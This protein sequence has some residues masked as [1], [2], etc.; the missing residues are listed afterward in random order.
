MNCPN[1]WLPL[2]PSN[3]FCRDCGTPV[4]AKPIPNREVVKKSSSLPWIIAFTSVFIALAVVTG[5]L[6][7]VSLRDAPD[8]TPTV[9]VADVL[10][11]E[12][13]EQ[14]LRYI[15]RA[16]ESI[17][18]PPPNPPPYVYFRPVIPPGGYLEHYVEPGQCLASIAQI[19][20]PHN[21]ETPTGRQVRDALVAHIAE[22]NDISDPEVLVVGTWLRI[23][24][25]PLLI[26]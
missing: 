16:L 23:Y 3:R 25:H 2:A 22:T 8:Y 6:L 12:S 18:N 13:I 19:Y 7:Q 14:R 17:E 24:E 5:V 21:P 15:E 10:I 4:N 1:C 26:Y 9:E 20:W 11:L